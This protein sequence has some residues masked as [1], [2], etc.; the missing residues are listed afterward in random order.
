MKHCSYDVIECAKGGIIM[1]KEWIVKKK[2][3]LAILAA[4]LCVAILGVTVGVMVAP[5]PAKND[6]ASLLAPE[7]VQTPNQEEPSKPE[8]TVPVTPS[9]PAKV[10]P[11]NTQNNTQEG[12]KPTGTPEK[13]APEAPKLNTPYDSFE[14]FEKGAMNVSATASVQNQ[15]DNGVV[16]AP[17]VVGGADTNATA[18][19]PQGVSVAQSTRALTLSVKPMDKTNSGIQP[20]EDQ[21]VEALDVHMDGVAATNTVPMLITLK[22]YLPMGLNDGNVKL[23]HV[24]KG[25]TV[26]MTCV[27]VPTNHNEFSYDSLTGNVTLALA[28]FSEVAV[29]AEANNPWDGTVAT[30]FAKGT[31]TEADPYLISTAHEMAYFRNQVDGGNTFA[32]KFV[33]LNNSISLGD[34]NFDPI[35]YGYECDKYMTDGMTFNGTFDGGNRTIFGLYQN[36]WELGSKYSYSM[37]GGGLFA[38]VVDATIK[39]VK[40]SGA[41]IVMECVDMGILVGYSQGEC[42]YE[43]IGIY[44]SKIANYQRATGGVVGEVSPRKNGDGSLMEGK[45][46]LHTFRNIEVA[47]DVVVGSLWGDFD[48]PCGGVLGARWD[49]FNATEVVMEDVKV[50]CRMDVYNDITAAYQWHAYRRAG[51]LIGNTDLPGDENRLAQAPFLTC[52]NV[53][54]Y[55]G[56][57]TNYTYCQFTNHNARYPWVRT[58]EGE[59]CEAFSN[60]RWGVP[61]DMN[62]NR[63][64]DMD[65]KHQEG[66]ECGITRSF[67]QLYGGGQGVYG[68]PKHPGVTIV[69]YQYAITY[70][71]DGDV[72]SIKYIT[73]SDIQKY[74]AID[75]NNNDFDDSAEK[76]VMEW[77]GNE[78]TGIVRFGGWMNAG[79]TKYNESNKIP[80]DNTKNIVLYPWFDSPYTAS[81]VDQNGNVL[82]SCFFTST[83]TSKLEATRVA[84]E[85]ALPDPGEK[86]ELDY[87][88]IYNNGK[89]VAYNVSNFKN[90][91]DVTVY[92]VYRYTG[93]LKLTP[94][95]EDGDGQTDYYRVDA[96]ANLDNEVNVPGK[97]NNIP[98]RI[99]SDLTS[100]RF[101]T[102]VSKIT[103]NEGTEVIE[104]ESLAGTGNLKEVVLPST[105]KTLSSKAFSSNVLGL[106]FKE[107]TITYNGTM[108][109]FKALVQNGWDEG[110]D[111]GSKVICTDGVGTLKRTYYVIGSRYDWT[112]TKN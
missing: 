98:V 63:V 49:D 109:E 23:Y 86:V 66:D 95:D 1:M 104:S 56:D 39:N 70:M 59:N 38:S 3:W 82:A 17:V 67:E 30:G 32:G 33:K 37:A 89:E 106:A 91:K 100:N 15:V 19:V 4:V 24:E 85:N 71:N 7:T 90:Y 34:V 65:H 51:M 40:I 42:T 111:T 36:G 18:E 27:K 57:W 105:L 92:P 5:E 50:G 61:N 77:A 20:G 2:G 107:M 88:A 46:S 55:Y 78:I 83:D 47:P 58:Q 25:N 80:A 52:K 110:L 43:N 73:E 94:V 41:N 76:V 74:G 22:S 8:E 62:G 45:K 64:T 69:D 9:G 103:I 72:L 16:S 60:P 53:Q 81:F 97:V 13:P 93:N 87:W 101:A 26:T 35:G 99:V 21:I 54:V 108:E 112:W 31:G 96:V 14:F 68:Q 10:E 6:S 48:A 11:E 28:N 29:V 44:N 102:N 79:S 12:A 75:P 84:A